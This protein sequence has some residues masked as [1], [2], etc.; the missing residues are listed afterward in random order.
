MNE[1]VGISGYVLRSY[2]DYI[3]ISATSNE[4]SKAYYTRGKKI[5]IT[6]DDVD[7]SSRCYWAHVYKEEN[8]EA[9]GKVKLY[10]DPRQQNPETGEPYFEELVGV[11]KWWWIDR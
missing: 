7:V 2:M 6:L 3:Y 1:E 11:V 4:Y 9:F 8:V 10:L 5:N